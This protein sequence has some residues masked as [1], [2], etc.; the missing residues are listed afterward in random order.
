M[1]LEDGRLIGFEA[2]LRWQHPTR[3]RI[4]P[5]RF[6]SIAEENSTIVAIGEWVLREACRQL[7]AWRAQ[8]AGASGLRMNINVS[9][10]QLRADDFTAIVAS[11]LANCDLEPDRISIEIT[12]SVLMDDADK[13]K[14]TLDA[15]RTLGV[16]IH[17]DDFGTGYSS[18]SYLRTFPIDALK[19]DRSFVSH[20]PA[21]DP[22]AG[23][24]SIEI[25]RTIVALAQ[26]LSLAVTAE[27]VETD[28]Q[29]AALRALGCRNGQG[30]LF[31]R[32]I[33]QQAAADFIIAHTPQ[34]TVLANATG[35]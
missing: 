19:I 30:Y 33:D 21:C 4:G 1:S 23:L 8:F 15:L 17:L 16:Q 2:L 11:A 31:S 34:T 24:A 25:V 22:D 9:A 32:P 14:A 35:P 7:Q 29:C 27:G 13:A 18:L 3:G 26:S 12:E 5:D 6:I 10:K 28:A 20:G